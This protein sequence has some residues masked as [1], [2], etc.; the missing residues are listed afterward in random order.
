MGWDWGTVGGEAPVVLTAVGWANDR[1]RTP[2]LGSLACLKAVLF[3]F[4]KAAGS[5]EDLYALCKSRLSLNYFI[6]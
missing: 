3:Q 2:L 1:A 4:F 5:H 6:I